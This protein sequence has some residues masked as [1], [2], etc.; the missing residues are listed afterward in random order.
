MGISKDD[1]QSQVRA[2]CR[3]YSFEDKENTFFRGALAAQNPRDYEDIPELTDDDKYWLRREVTN[4]WHLPKA[5]YYTIAICSLGSAIQ[6]WDNTGANGANLS[7]PKEFGI[8]DNGW[9]VGVINSGPTLFGLLSAWAADPVNN[10]LGR[11]GTVF[12]TGLFCIFPVLAQAFT[13]NW[14]GL[15]ICRLFMGLGMGI[16]ISTIPVFSAEVAPASIRGGLVTS[17]QL[18]VSFGMFVGYCCNLIFYRVGKLAW[19]FQLASAFVPAIPVVIFLWFCPGM[20]I[21][22]S[23]LKIPLEEH[24][25]TVSSRIAS[26]AD[27]KGAICRL[28]PIILSIEEY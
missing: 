4:R 21:T 24:K 9:L 8:E 2:F 26:M 1:L 5:L 18:W 6:G 27:E 19:R 20:A 12:V 23:S 10:L 25:L 15:L 28:L 7:F 14:W 13:Q 22:P 17:F 16:K 3:E 11:R